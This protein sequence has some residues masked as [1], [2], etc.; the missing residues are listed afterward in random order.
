ML[1]VSTRIIVSLFDYLGHKDIS[2]D[3]IFSRIGTE[4]NCEILIPDSLRLNPGYISWS[5]FGNILAAF[6]EVV[7]NRDWANDF[8]NYSISNDAPWIVPIRSAAATLTTPFHFY[9]FITNWYPKI[10]FPIASTNMIQDQD[11]FTVT[12]SVPDDERK[13]LVFG[14]LEELFVQAP[15]I[16]GLPE[17]KVTRSGTGNRNNFEIIVANNNTKWSAFA[18]RLKQIFSDKGAD[19]TS[20]V[21]NF[22]LQLAKSYENLL[23][24][25]VGFQQKN[26]HLETQI[27]SQTTE[28]AHARGEVREHQAYLEAIFEN[29]DAIVF[30]TDKH[31]DVLSANEKYY[32]ML[33]T[34]G[35]EYR[36]TK[37]SLAEE[38]SELVATVYRTGNK[39]ETEYS[40]QTKNA[41]KSYAIKSS[42]VHDST[43]RIIACVCVGID[44]T[45]QKTL[46]GILSESTK[47]LEINTRVRSMFASNVSHELRT[48][49][50]SI[51]G[52]VELLQSREVSREKMQV[53]LGIIKSNGHLLLGLI[54]NLLDIAK[55]ESGNKVAES[56]PI[57][58][59]ACF[60]DIRSTVSKIVTEKD[61]EFE[62]DVSASLP[63]LIHSDRNR[64]K[65][66]LECLIDNALKFTPSGF[67]HVSIELSEHS[68]DKKHE[69]LD[70][71]VRDNGKGVEPQHLSLLFSP[72]YMG[73]RKISS[74]M[75]GA[76]ISLYLSKKIAQELGGDIKHIDDSVKGAHFV[77][78]LNTGIEIDMNKPI[79]PAPE[80]T[81]GKD[82][83][84]LEGKR[85]LF[86]DDIADIQMLY[87][88]ILKL[89]GARVDVA[90]NGKIGIDLATTNNYDII[91]VDLKMPEV[92]GFEATRRL[93]S[94]GF[95][96]PII[97]LT[98]YARPQERTLSLEAGCNDHISKPVG[99]SQLVEKIKIWL[100]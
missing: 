59:Q 64:I 22:Y 37:Q 4:H 81:I 27:K 96:I 29:I 46:D 43:G 17:S 73:D 51:L 71:H 28:I 26:Q 49:L 13:E 1:D 24:E 55:I 91:I 86:M 15:K 92:D 34:N 50:T 62:F 72:D 10:E 78:Q 40:F 76:G 42:P 90:D 89:A 20:T 30:L 52:F 2:L 67:V 93:R 9:N 68:I 14:L 32:D 25:R 3:Q 33:S 75:P 19:N 53:Y 100:E 7:K 18:S 38:L 45:K 23:K 61:I 74:E 65:Q 99:A 39:S 70:I 88:T 44:I 21:Q 63:A 54:N 83:E 95:K 85:I 84:P 69:Y 82:S 97:A 57:D 11:K 80:A 41:E 6:V 77:F 66:V 60:S 87:S 31:G 12:V 36:R 98:S 16:I 58:S 94:A 56:L 5:L 8:V 35:K 48:P 79:S 47:G